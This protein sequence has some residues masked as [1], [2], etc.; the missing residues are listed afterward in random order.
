MTPSLD[1]AAVALRIRALC[2]LHGSQAEVVRLCGIDPK[3]LTNAINM[4]SLPGA[5]TLG[6]ISK[7]L[8][9][10]VDWILFGEE[11]P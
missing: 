7:G 6:A 11:R 9:V 4:T 2:E 10:S 1:P 5:M 3:T 8:G